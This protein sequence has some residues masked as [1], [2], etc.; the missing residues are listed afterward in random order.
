MDEAQ[1]NVSAYE[2]LVWSDPSDGENVA[3]QVQQ[4]G[5]DLSATPIDDLPDEMLVLIINLVPLSSRYR[6]AHISKRFRALDAHLPGVAFGDDGKIDAF[7]V[8]TQ[9][10]LNTALDAPPE[11]D[12][13][14]ITLH[15]GTEYVF[16]RPPNNP[17]ALIQV[18]DPE[19]VTVAALHAGKLFVASTD[20][21]IHIK[22]MTG[23]YFGTSGKMTIDSFTGGEIRCLPASSGSIHI[24]ADGPIAVDDY[25]VF[26]DG[27]MIIHSDQAGRFIPD[28]VSVT[29]P[30]GNDVPGV[31]GP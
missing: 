9:P 4:M 22:E 26:L 6:L 30:D 12:Y 14:F 11:E 20:T 27:N 5:I 3:G 21:D 1:Q 28:D 8:S 25:K 2:A 15:P 16:N 17:K 13:S 7:H 31:H 18:E 29:G 19:R 23:G 10:Q 24:A